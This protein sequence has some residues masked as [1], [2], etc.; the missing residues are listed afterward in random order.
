MVIGDVNGRISEVFAKLAALQAKQDFAFAIVA[1]N[2]FRNPDEANE[3][4]ADDVTNVLDG[5]IAIPLPTYFTL[6]RH[7]LP[8]RVEER[9]RSNDGELCPNLTAL[10]R[11]A[12][13]KTT[14][15]FKMV[16]I[17]GVRRGAD[18]DEPMTEWTASYTDDDANAAISYTDADVLI[19]S[20]WPTS[21][22]TGAKARY[23]GVEC[24]EAQSIADLCSALKPR[25]HFSTSS[26]FYEREP[27]FHNVEPPRP[28]TRFISLAPF[29]NASKEKWIYAFSLE[30]SAEPPN[31]LPP[32][33]TASPLSSNRKRKLDSQQNA[34]NAV[35]FSNG[36]ARGSHD[37]HRGKRSRHARRPDPD[38]CYFCLS[39]PA[40]ETHMIGSIGNDAYLTIAKGPLT[41]RATFPSLDFPG[42]LLIIPLHHSPT[43]AAIPGEE[44][45][46][47]TVKEMQRYRS[48]LHSLLTARS[49]DTDGRSQVGA[50]TW[51]ISRASGVHNHWQFLPVPV[52]LV[53]KGLV[54]GAFKIEAENLDYPAFV[55]SASQI[56]SVEE[57]SYFKV[58]IWSEA[59][60]TEMVMPLDKS[61]RF[62]LQFG[63]RVLGKLLG[64]ESRTNWKDCGQTKAEESEDAER[65]KKMF[66]GFDFSLE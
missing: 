64:L 23:G 2:L 48:A 42:H 9:L 18:S 52:E 20:D 30:P 1:G 33:T 50:V 26:A 66:E 54:E 12:R 57:G 32:G 51:E 47:A 38:E 46:E 61:F 17:C 28:I 55:T 24:H 21:I 25:Y 49:K 35:R 16:A 29:G 10:G 15:G 19:T 7:E 63:R 37:N 58:M 43:I 14:E 27:F 4:S 39:N 41:T 5:K 6:G 40:C 44:A 56:A 45:R 31:T 11:K 59:L 65:F 8:P 36:D 34:F 13:V 3:S 53:Q 22:R 62:D 60:R